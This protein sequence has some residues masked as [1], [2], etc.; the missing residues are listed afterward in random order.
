GRLCG[1]GVWGRP[2]PRRALLR[3]PAEYAQ[4]GGRGED[5]CV[6]GGSGAPPHGPGVQ[7][8]QLAADDG[9]PVDHVRVYVLWAPAL[10]ATLAAPGVAAVPCLTGA[11][12]CR[13]R[14][15]C[16]HGCI[17]SSS[18]ST[19]LPRWSLSGSA[20]SFP[21]GTLA[22]IGGPGGLA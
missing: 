11:G 15:A 13:R 21:M 8:Q 10:L 14:Q 20:A 7:S 9:P 5:V 1:A 2:R 4:T 3:H 22:C 19:R 12:P 16:A 6:G 17:R 18:R